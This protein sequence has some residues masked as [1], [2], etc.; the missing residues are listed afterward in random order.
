MSFMLVDLYGWQDSP[1]TAAR[2]EALFSEVNG[3]ES[4]RFNSDAVFLRS[5]F[6][7]ALVALAAKK[8]LADGLSESLAESLHFLSENHV[9]PNPR[10]ALR[11]GEVEEGS[12]VE[13][14][15]E[16][17]G[18]SF[19]TAEPKTADLIPFSKP[20]HR[21]G[22][23][24]SLEPTPLVSFSLCVSPTQP[25]TAMQ[26]L[27]IVTFS[28]AR[29]DRKWS[30]NDGHILNCRVVRVHVSTGYSRVEGSRRASRNGRVS[31]SPTRNPYRYDSQPF[32]SRHHTRASPSPSAFCLKVCNHQR[33][34]DGVGHGHKL[35]PTRAAVHAP[36][37]RLLRGEQAAAQSHLR[38]LPRH[39]PPHG[40]QP[41]V[42]VCWAHY[43]SIA[44]LCVLT[45]TIRG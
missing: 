41:L 1:C 3:S 12:Q 44:E 18:P 30:L 36:R 25:P 40:T 6:I 42:P 15:R 33:V 21:F 5:E 34:Q 2:M 20:T 32:A 43:K 39:A 16:K 38:H 19:A 24:A 27:R 10:R 35:V 11:H 26:K 17:G 37:G 8:F 22:S 45:K 14:A 31:D 4:T 7:H 28:L 23:A 13:G 29:G 9:K